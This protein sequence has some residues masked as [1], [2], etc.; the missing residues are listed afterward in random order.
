M[1]HDAATDVAAQSMMEAAP[2]RWLLLGF[3]PLQLASSER[4]VV[5][6]VDSS[7]PLN[8]VDPNWYVSSYDCP[9]KTIFTD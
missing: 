7:V 9:P 6:C 4:P 5:L 1:D 2:S 8:S 3:Y